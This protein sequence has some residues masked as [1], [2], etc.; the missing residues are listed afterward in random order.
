M[1]MIRI[2]FDEADF[3]S[4]YNAATKFV[5]ESEIYQDFLD[6][7]SDDDYIAEIK[8]MNDEDE[9]PPVVA[10]VEN[11]GTLGDADMSDYEKI[12][13]GMC[14]SYI[15]RE[16]YGYSDAIEVRIAKTNGVGGIK[17]ASYFV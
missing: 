6:A 13:I 3:L 12:C 7:I 10:L 1:G 5:E 4:K 2:A 17:N 9:Y 11:Y 15:F 16:I 8:R 14:M